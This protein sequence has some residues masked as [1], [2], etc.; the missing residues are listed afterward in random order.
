[1]SHP[2]RTPKKVETLSKLHKFLCKFGFH[3]WKTRWTTVLVLDGSVAMPDGHECLCCGEIKVN[4]K[5]EIQ[6]YSACRCRDCVQEVIN[7][8]NDPIAE[9]W[10]KLR[11]WCPGG[12]PVK[13]VAISKDVLEDFIKK[14]ESP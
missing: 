14:S 12:G 4:S 11:V 9:P 2:Y 13:A 3:N 10:R 7:S 5:H 1:M 6:D 8:K